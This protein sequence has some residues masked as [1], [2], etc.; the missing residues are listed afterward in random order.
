[1]NNR[2][3][4]DVI[5]L[6]L[7]NVAVNAPADTNEN[8]LATITVPGRAMGLNGRLRV[9][10]AWSLTNNANAKSLL[11]RFSGAAGT[12]FQSASGASVAVY[13]A[14]CDIMNVNAANAQKGGSPFSGV[15]GSGASAFAT[16]AVDT[17]GDTTIVIR[18]QKGT[19]GDTITLES[20]LV[21]LIPG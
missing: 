13:K 11:V 15:L 17:T 19:A 6:A 8:T 16:S 5:V 3:K 9:T 7:S 14:V 18:A 12:T 1:M 4:S 10:T 20:Y 2:P 21:E